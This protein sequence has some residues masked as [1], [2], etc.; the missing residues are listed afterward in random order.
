MPAFGPAPSPLSIAE[1]RTSIQARCALRPGQKPAPQLRRSG[2]G[3]GDR[4]QG[5][6][7]RRVCLYGHV[8]LLAARGPGSKSREEETMSS[9]RRFTPE[10]KLALVLQSHQSTNV[11]AFCRENG[12]DRTT[13]YA[14]RQELSVAALAAWRARRPGRPSSTSKDTVESLRGALQMAFDRCR[15]LE[16]EAR[17]W[18]I[19]VELADKL[20]ATKQP[21]SIQLLA[22]ALRR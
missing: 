2:E 7:T 1:S 21:E 20:A 9:L 13:L 11:Q 17:A 6:A 22:I 14:W 8:G 19:R 12:L 10:E 4:K 18:R 3:D 16:Q 5:A 15:F